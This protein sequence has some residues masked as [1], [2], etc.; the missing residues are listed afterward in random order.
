MMDEASSH[1]YHYTTS[2]AAYTTPYTWILVQ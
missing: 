2:Q 1:H